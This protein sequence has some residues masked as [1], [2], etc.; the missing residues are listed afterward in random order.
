MRP[1]SI[2]Q[3]APIVYRISDIAGATA[4]SA[5]RLAIRP[6][7][8]WGRMRGLFARFAMWQYLDYR[9]RGEL[10]MRYRKRGERELRLLKYLVDPTRASIDVGANKGVYTYWLERFSRFVYA[11]EPNPVLV[12]AFLR[13]VRGNAEVRP[14]AASDVD[15]T[16]ALRV[17]LVTAPEWN[18]WHLEHQGG[19]LNAKRVGSVFAE[20]PIRTCRLDSLAHQPVGFMKIDVEGHELA[21]L[22]GARQLI[23]RDHPVIMIELQQTCYDRPLAE[24]IRGIEQL[25]YVAFVLLPSGLAPYAMAPQEYFNERTD[26]PYFIKNVIFFPVPVR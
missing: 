23:A 26:H 17:T 3:A 14:C 21:V 8:K 1:P 16:D 20:Y 19:S 15:G 13:G 4:Q 12:D 10:H 9:L 18:A 7:D 5:E 25:G 22:D 2:S 11:Y 24:V 6:R